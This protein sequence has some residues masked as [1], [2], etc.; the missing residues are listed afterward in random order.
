MELQAQVDLESD[1]EDQD[2]EVHLIFALSYF[3]FHD[4]EFCVVAT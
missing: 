1:D 4:L 3:S 2:E